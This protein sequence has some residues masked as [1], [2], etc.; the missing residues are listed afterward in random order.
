MTSAFWF[1]GNPA[2]I[3][4]IE[5]IGT[6]SKRDH[7]W[8]EDTYMM[9]SHYFAKVDGKRPPSTP[10]KWKMPAKARD[11]FMVYGVWWKDPQ[12]LWMY[13]NG[14]KILEIKTSAP[15][16]RPQYMFFDTEVFSWHGWPKPENLLD[17]TKNTMLVDWVR[18]WTLKKI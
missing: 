13:H 4:V 2:E 16:D 15:F 3:D 9:N 12:T 17:D 11:E 8:I 6:P 7:A 18:A 10:K 14:A 1:Q 5:N